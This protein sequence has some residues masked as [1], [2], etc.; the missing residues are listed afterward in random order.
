[1]KVDVKID[2]R[3]KELMVRILTNQINDDV[4]ELMG[5]ISELDQ[6]QIMGYRETY[7]EVL[8]ES[9]IITIYSEGQKVFAR[10]KEGVYRL[11]QR[12]YQIEELLEKCHYVRISNSELINMDWIKRLDLSLNGTV[13]I[14]FKDGTTTFVSRRYVKKVKNKLGV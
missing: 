3:Y 12:L 13:C 6:K 8:K 4:E 1:M 2:E 7:F 11:K 14:Y 9:E 10:T 5:K